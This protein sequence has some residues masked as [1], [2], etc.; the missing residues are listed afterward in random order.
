MCVVCVRVGTR[1]NALWATINDDDHQVLTEEGLPAEG[2]QIVMVAT[3]IS[4]GDLESMGISYIPDYRSDKFGTAH[5]SP[6]LHGPAGT[7][8]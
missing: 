4:P 6:P 1:T 5:A 7:A 3:S 8:R 2:R